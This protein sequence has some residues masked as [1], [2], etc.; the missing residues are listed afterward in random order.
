M[1]SSPTWLTIVKKVPGTVQRSQEARSGGDGKNIIPPL[2]CIYG[3]P[4][5]YE[6]LKNTIKQSFHVA[7]ARTR[8]E[9]PP[10]DEYESSHGSLPCLWDEWLVALRRP[11]YHADPHV[12]RRRPESSINALGAARLSGMWVCD[13]VFGESDG[14][15]AMRPGQITITTRR[16]PTGSNQVAPNN[17]V[18]LSG[19]SSQKSTPPCPEKAAGCFWIKESTLRALYHK[20]P[21]RASLAGT[22]AGLVFFYLFIFQ[23]RP[24]STFMLSLPGIDPNGVV[25]VALTFGVCVGAAIVVGS[26]LHRIGL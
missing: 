20:A 16:W 11:D 12:G 18:I 19:P 26:L 21:G 6:G 22:I 4:G 24:I 13:A 15:G 5:V 10:L 2:S 3:L 9:S 17:T 25:P 1:G 23:F 8:V 7:Y 14:R